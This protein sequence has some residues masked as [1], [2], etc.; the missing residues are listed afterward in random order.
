MGHGHQPLG[1]GVVVEELH[2]VGAPFPCCICPVGSGKTE[3]RMFFTVL[4]S[5]L[6]WCLMRGF[7]IQE[8]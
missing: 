1:A 7:V 3:I 5:T 2:L 4:S 6:S 8:V